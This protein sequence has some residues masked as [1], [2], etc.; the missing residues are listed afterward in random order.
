MTWIKN[1]L[2]SCYGLFLPLDRVS[3][4]QSIESF[5]EYSNAILEAV[6]VGIIIVVSLYAL[7]YA[8][9]QAI[10]KRDGNTVF[11]ETRFRLIRG[12]LLGLDFLVAADI[13]RTVV[14]ELSYE[15]VGVLAII[16]IIRIIL[17]FSLEVEVTGLW[18]W[19]KNK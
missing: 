8:L 17:S 10:K 18:P 3:L 7:G 16:V 13:I 4:H 12:I 15:S 14:V 19:Q 5:G 2:F 9:L 1:I 6:G 11:H